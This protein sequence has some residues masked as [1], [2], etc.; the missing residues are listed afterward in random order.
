MAN[1]GEEAVA[2]W[3]QVLAEIRL[4]APTL[5]QSEVQCVAIVIMLTRVINSMRAAS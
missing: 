3:E 5:P 1:Q 4:A 2:A